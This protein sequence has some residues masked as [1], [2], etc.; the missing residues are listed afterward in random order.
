MNPRLSSDEYD[1]FYSTTYK[2]PNEAFRARKR[3]DQ[4]LKHLEDRLGSHPTI[5]EVG[6]SKG[7]LLAALKSRFNAEVVGIE[8]SRES[9]EYARTKYRI[10][11]ITASLFDVNWHGNQ[12]DVI[13]LSHVLEHFLQP[14]EALEKLRSLAKPAT[15]LYVQVPNLFVHPCF[16]IGHTYSFCA[17]TLTNMLRKTGWAPSRIFTNPH[18]GTL[19]P[20]YNVTAFATPAQPQPLLPVNYRSIITGRKVG[21]ALAALPEAVTFSRNLALQPCRTV[22]GKRYQTAARLYRRYRWKDTSE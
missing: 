16:E 21:R 2:I 18:G 13:I 8:P 19:L 17:E 14:A 20:P 7:M 5:L 10:N 3:T 4:I 1:H 12:P 11:V 22:L 6:C 9:A 15:L